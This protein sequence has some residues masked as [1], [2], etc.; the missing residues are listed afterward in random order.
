M[1]GKRKQKTTMTKKVI[2][3]FSITT[4][5]KVTIFGGESTSIQFDGHKSSRRIH[6]INHDAM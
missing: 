4:K 1:Q 3:Y 6:I 5:P 2:V